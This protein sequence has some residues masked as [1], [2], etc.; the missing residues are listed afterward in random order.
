[1]KFT[2]RPGAVDAGWTAL[3]SQLTKCLVVCEV[4]CAI[5]SHLN[6]KTVEAL[7]ADGGG[8]DG[9]GGDGDGGDR[10]GGWWV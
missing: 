3:A 5:D 1:M 7:R 2:A 10:G 9:G 4:S 6:R 8:G